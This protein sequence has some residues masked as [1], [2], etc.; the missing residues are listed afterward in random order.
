MPAT[1][2]GGGKQ[3]LRQGAGGWCDTAALLSWALFVYSSTGLFWGI[4]LLLQQYCCTPMEKMKIIYCTRYC[5]THVPDT[6]SSGKEVRSGIVPGTTLARAPGAPRSTHKCQQDGQK[7]ATSNSPAAPEL[8]QWRQCCLL[9][10]AWLQ[11]CC[12]CCCC[13]Y[14]SGFG[15]GHVGLVGV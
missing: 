15:S 3:N 10:F 1:N 8:Q 2:A 11:Y 5:S 4:L 6:K 7:C 9:C 13:N 12:C 14:G